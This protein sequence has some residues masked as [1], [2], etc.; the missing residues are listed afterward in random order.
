MNH[1][2]VV[3]IEGRKTRPPISKLLLPFMEAVKQVVEK[4]RGYSL[5]ARSV[6]YLL[7]NDPPLMRANDPNSRYA[8][9]HACYK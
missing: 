9:N 3:R 2:S 4:R 7:M 1:G 6:H 8:N 5:S